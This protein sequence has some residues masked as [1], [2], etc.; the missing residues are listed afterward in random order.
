MTTFLKESE[1]PHGGI[2]ALIGRHSIVGHAGRMMEIA[3]AYVSEVVHP[4]LQRTVTLTIRES[5]I[6][7]PV[8]AHTAKAHHDPCG[9]LAVGRTPRTKGEVG[10]HL[11]QDNLQTQVQLFLYLCTISSIILIGGQRVHDSSHHVNAEL[12]IIAIVQNDIDQVL[13]RPSGIIRNGVDSHVQSQ[14]RKNGAVDG[15]LTGI[16]VECCDKV[17]DLIALAVDVRFSIVVLREFRAVKTTG[18]QHHDGAV[19]LGH[20]HI[21]GRVQLCKLCGNVE[22]VVGGVVVFWQVFIEAEVHPLPV[23]ICFTAIPSDD[24][25]TNLLKLA[26]ILI[27]SSFIRY[28]NCDRIGFR[29]LLVLCCDLIL[30]RRA[31]ILYLARGR[32]NRGKLRNFDGRRENRRDTL[33]QCH[34]DLSRTLVDLGFISTIAEGCNLTSCRCRSAGD[35]HDIVLLSAVFRSHGIVIFTDLK[36]CGLLCHFRKFGYRYI[37]LCRG[38]VCG[39][40]NR[41]GHT[42]FGDRT[43]RITDL[44]G[45]NVILRRFFRCDRNIISSFCLILRVVNDQSD[46]FSKVD[47]F[48]FITSLAVNSVIEAFTGIIHLRGQ[49]GQIGSDRQIQLD[50]P[51]ASVLA[52]RDAGGANLAIS[53]L[54]VKGKHLC[55]R[56]SIFNIDRPSLAQILFESVSGG[57]AAVVI[58]SRCAVPRCHCGNSLTILQTAKILDKL[59]LIIC[60][61]RRRGKFV[62][63][64]IFR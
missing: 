57:V 9:R 6:G 20:C 62:P 27:G 61:N 50:R 24:I 34:G 45:E 36:P 53:C 56:S 31:K 19:K 13:P 32:R 33:R 2:A 30:N 55:V 64:G 4:V 17:V 63:V 37:R 52:I 15:V 43:D 38:K 23:I 18:S 46:F 47:L 44:I 5:G 42:A 26:Y 7:I 28:Y 3:A 48:S 40:R 41:Y 59:A 21:C 11:S 49:R 39:I 25:V 12:V 60:L 35:R 58:G 22:G 8:D 54:N 10:I 1:I 29:Y 51:V 14:Q 16:V